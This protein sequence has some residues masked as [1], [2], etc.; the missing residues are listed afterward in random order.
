MRFFLAVKVTSQKCCSLHETKP[1]PNPT[2]PTH[3]MFPS[4]WSATAELLTETCKGIL[5]LQ[6]TCL[7]VDTALGGN[8]ICLN[9][10]CQMSPGGYQIHST[11]C[12]SYRPCT[13]SFSFNL[14]QKSGA[15]PGKDSYR[16]CY[17]LISFS[18]KEKEIRI[19]NVSHI[20]KS[21]EK[22]GPI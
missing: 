2:P 8:H 16:Y 4:V 7:G 20:A 13:T 21:P 9:K 6:H 15:A 11:R 19:L 14:T 22:S 1:E 10:Q 18:Q 3:C 17:Q 5:F 12:P